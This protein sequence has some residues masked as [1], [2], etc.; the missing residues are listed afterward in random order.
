M[1]IVQMI[2]VN[3]IMNTMEL[4]AN[5]PNAMVFFQMK[6]GYVLR[7]ENVLNQINASVKKD[8]MVIIVIPIVAMKYSIAIQVCVVEKETAYYQINVNVIQFILK[9]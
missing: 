7:M 6:V 2:N 9:D 3:A 5:I 4:I 8:I 1:D